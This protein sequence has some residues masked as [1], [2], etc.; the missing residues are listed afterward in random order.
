MYRIVTLEPKIKADNITF[1]QIQDLIRIGDDTQFNQIHIGLD[2]TV[3][4]VE[5]ID[6]NSKVEY[7]A[8]MPS[9]APGGKY[10]GIE[11]SEDIGYINKIFKAINYHYKHGFQEKYIEIFYGYGY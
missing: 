5:G 1:K 8:V 2:N 3:F 9:F 7:K 6:G 4:I 11:A 10:V